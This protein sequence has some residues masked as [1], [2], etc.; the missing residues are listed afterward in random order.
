MWFGRIT[1]NYDESGRRRAYKTKND[2]RKP[3]HTRSGLAQGVEVSHSL[4][5]EACQGETMQRSHTGASMRN[6]S[7][8][9]AIS[10]EG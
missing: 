3:P 8:V 2:I 1:K 7:N 5:V 9:R 4:G 10:N 6:T